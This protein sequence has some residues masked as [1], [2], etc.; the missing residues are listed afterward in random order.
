MTESNLPKNT[1]RHDSRS[2]AST[3]KETAMPKT[4][5]RAVLAGAATIPALSILSLPALGNEPDDPIYAAIERHK[6][7][8]IE[9][10]YHSR[11]CF[12]MSPNHPEYDAR[13]EADS[14]PYEKRDAAAVDLANTQP[15]TLAGVFAFLEYIEQ[16]NAGKFYNSVDPL[17]WHSDA[18]CW[19]TVDAD[20]GGVPENVF[21]FEMLKTIHAALKQVVPTGAAHKTMEG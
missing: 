14:R 20:C 6:A 17:N 10:T 18:A 13:E 4:T 15:T 1:E 3:G 16:F 19:P 21:P 7:A 8:Y 11:I 9:Q 12:H 2:G 5:R